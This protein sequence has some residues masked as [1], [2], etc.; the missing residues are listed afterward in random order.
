[1]ITAR[2][3][4]AL[5]H[6]PLHRFFSRRADRPAEDSGRVAVPTT[7]IPRVIASRYDRARTGP[8]GRS[9]KSPTSHARRGSAPFKCRWY[10]TLFSMTAPTSARPGRNQPCHCGSGRKYKHCCLEKDGAQAGAARAKAAAEAAAGSS[11]AAASAPA[12]AP[13]PQTHQPWKATTSRGFVPRTRTPRK[14]GGS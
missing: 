2:R 4:A 6:C 14:V 8:R 3:G 1:M 5:E 12:R 11:E 7:R 9:N 10:G 13:K